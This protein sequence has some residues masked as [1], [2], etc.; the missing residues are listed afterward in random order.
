ML[1]KFKTSK[2]YK[3]INKF[4]A[5]AILALLLSVAFF[6]YDVMRDKSQDKLDNEHFEKTV[7]KLEE[8]SQS[9]STRFLGTFPEYL[10]EINRVFRKLQPQDTV[11]I[12]EDVLYYGIKSRPQEFKEFNA[13]ILNHARQG[14][15]V[16][17]V[18]YDNHP[19]KRY[20]S[21]FHR[22]VVES[23]IS[24]RY[25]PTIMQ[26]REQALKKIPKEQLCPKVVMHYDSLMIDKYF[27]QSMNDNL[28]RA[29]DDRKGYLNKDLVNGIL[30]T[31]SDTTIGVLVSQICIELDSI[32]QHYLG[33]NKK[34]SDIHFVDYE[35]MYSDMTDC[36]AGFYH[37]ENITL[38]PIN[39]Y[40][41]MSCWLIKPSESTKSSEAILAFP[42][43]YNSD[44]IGFYSQDAAFAQYISMM[45]KGVQGE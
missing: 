28:Q 8:I 6:G 7:H 16:V 17:V 14:G 39:E 23:R 24:M 34:L 45:L 22:M 37:R 11:I 27:V 42:S 21:V 38:I 30:P 31:Y 9:L 13:I 20:N 25:I 18:Y 43:K 40:L 19:R 29:K 32:K 2:A 44:E 41:T 35:H 15:R 3:I 26:E 5:S 33:G 1:D 36:I 4:A 12:F 10:T